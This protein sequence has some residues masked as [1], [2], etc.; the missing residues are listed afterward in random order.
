MIFFDLVVSVGVA[1][2]V[3][4][5]NTCLLKPPAITVSGYRWLD[6]PVS[7]FCKKELEP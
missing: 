1:R 5:E 3:K 2:P 7:Q 6:L 4:V